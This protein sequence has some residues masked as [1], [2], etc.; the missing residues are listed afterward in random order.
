MSTYLRLL[1][2]LR[3]YRSQ[4]TAAIVCMVIYAITTTISLSL[5]S[6]F[7]RVLFERPGMALAQTTSPAPIAD[8][9]RIAGAPHWPSFVRETIDRLLVQAPP[10]VA[11]ERICIVLLLL[12]LLKNRADYL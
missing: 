8:S 4:L 3:P 1:G 2:Y 11:L 10:L 7:M 5:V 9:T 12:R 6:P